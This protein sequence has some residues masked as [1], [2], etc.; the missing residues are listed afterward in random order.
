MRKAMPTITESAAE[1]QRQMQR[2]TD[3]KKRQRLHALYLAASGQARHRQEIAALL[4]VHRHS[5]AAWFEAYARGGLAQALRYQVSTPPVPR[6]L[7]ETAV[8]ALQAKLNDS[9]GF[10][11]YAQSRRWLA[12]EHHVTLSYSRVHALVRYKLRA[13]PTRPRP[14]HA[15]KAWKL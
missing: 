12:E 8:T 3:G 5:I 13:K 1:L 15:K 10:A 2:E 6:R 4:G 11:G 7:T 14:S 9:K